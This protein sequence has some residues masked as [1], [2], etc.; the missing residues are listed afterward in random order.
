MG[1]DVSCQT[2]YLVP[3]V[4][5]DLYPTDEGGLQLP[6]G[7]IKLTGKARHLGP[8]GKHLSL[9]LTRLGRLNSKQT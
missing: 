4:L 2:S 5:F 7:S 3:G 8:S 6:P 1:V 9:G